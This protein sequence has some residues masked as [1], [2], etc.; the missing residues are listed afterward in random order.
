MSVN[1]ECPIMILKDPIGR[2][3]KHN[4]QYV[5]ACCIDGSIKSLKVSKLNTYIKK[6]VN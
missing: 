4:G 6:T 5:F 2:D 1:A 3:K